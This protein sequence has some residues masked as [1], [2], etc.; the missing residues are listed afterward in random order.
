M[1]SNNNLILSVPAGERP[2]LLRL[3]AF[4]CETMRLPAGDNDEPL[5]YSAGN[6]G[7]NVFPYEDDWSAELWYHGSRASTWLYGLAD[8]EAMRLQ[9]SEAG[10]GL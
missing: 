4:V 1:V 2:D 5:T 3:V 8:A 7:A 10:G 6:F 9:L